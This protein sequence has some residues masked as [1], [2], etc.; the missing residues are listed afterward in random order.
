[1]GKREFARPLSAA[2]CAGKQRRFGLAATLHWSRWRLLAAFAALSL[3]ILAQ[4][5]EAGTT[6]T[7][8]PNSALRTGPS[9]QLPD[10]RAFE[11]VSPLEKGGYA[12]LLAGFPTQATSDGEAISYMSLGAFSGAAGA[13]FPDAYVSRRNKGGWETTNVSPP[14]PDATPP[15]GDPITYNFSND[16]SQLAIELP[17]QQLAVGATPEVSNLFQTSTAVGGYTWVNDITPHLLLPQDC[18]RPEFLSLCWQAVDLIAFAG[19]SSDYRHILFESTESL[20]TGA[21]EGRENLYESTFEAGEW[22]VKPVGI[23]PDEAA[24]QGSAAGGGSTVFY[25]TVQPQ[26]DKRVVNA[27][28]EDGSHVVFKA[29]ADGGVPDPAQSG[30]I[31]V[32]DR[33]DGNE[34]IELSAPAPGASPEFTTPE[35]AT[36]WAASS[37]GRRVFF[38]SRAELTTPSYTGATEPE[39]QDLYEYDLEAKMLRDL[40]VDTNLPADEEEGA[41]VQGVVGA[42]SD[43]SYVYFV[44]KG[45]L[46]PGMGADHEDNLYVVHNDGPPTFIATLNESDRADWTEAT[47]LLEAYVTP[48]GKRLAFT[49]VNSLQTANFPSGYDNVNTET[50]TAEREVYE[51]SAPTSAE[52]EHGQTGKLVCASCNPSGAPPRAP[53]VLGGVRRPEPEAQGTS[54]STPFHQVRAVSDNGERVFFSSRDPLTAAAAK[55]NAKAKV[56][57]YEQVGEGSCQTE[58]GCIYL[59]S[60]PTSP[61]E[62][63]FLDADSNGDNVFVATVS[64][65]AAS[66]HDQLLDV[67][68]AR[69]YGGLASVPAELPCGSCRI[70]STESVAATNPLSG[71]AGKS[72]NLLPQSKIKPTQSKAKKLSAALKVCRKKRNRQRRRSCEANAHKRYGLASK[73]HT[74]G[75][76]S[77]SMGR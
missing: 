72:G 73:A 39:G 28:S 11:Q 13:S 71:T 58:T 10:C 68:D 43:G 18:P 36:F 63:F 8:C 60:S 23:L 15:G 4:S 1:M 7:A 64:Q 25:A 20:A 48:D 6:P 51:Y 3:G 30:K 62:A 47:A 19:G 75:H 74:S 53:G 54:Q 50:S 32:Y 59:L 44:A 14:S 65:L 76:L 37:D 29:A 45:Q 35:S 77:A 41:A 66:D 33:M 21:P 34:T 22:H 67:Y 16:L 56:Y 26:F 61:Q 31:E 5:S 12:A 57:E 9:M 52:E 40:T 2:G 38:T 69:V 55:G 17:L 42:S 27:I 49:S 24:A 70:A 46:V